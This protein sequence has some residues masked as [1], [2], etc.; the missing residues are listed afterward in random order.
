MGYLQR[1]TVSGATANAVRDYQRERSR[2]QNAAITSVETG[3][4]RFASPESTNA[5]SQL[6]ATRLYD[7][8]GIGDVDGDTS[9]MDVLNTFVGKAGEGV[10]NLIGGRPVTNNIVAAPPKASFPWIPAIA[11]AGGAAVLLLLLRKKG[12]R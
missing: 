7:S 3:I 11:V 5:Y 8:P 6:I 2:A 9:W 12:R 4:N 1:L 10:S